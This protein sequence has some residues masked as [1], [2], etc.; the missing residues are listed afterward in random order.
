VNNLWNIADLIDLHFFFQADEEL[1]RREGEAALAKRDRIIYVAKIEPQLGKMDDIPPRILVRKWLAM[2]RLQYRQERG[3]EGQVLPGTLWQELALLCRGLVF[4]CGLLAGLGAAGSLLLYSGTTPL[5]VAVYFGLF[6][7]LQLLLIGVQGLLFGYRQ[8]RRQT[9]ESTVLYAMLGRLLMRGLDGIRRRLQR[10]LSGQRRLDLAALLGGVQQ[11]KE[12]AV[13]LIWP[14]FILVQLGGVGFNLGVLGATLAKVTFADIAFAWQSSLQ[15]SAEMVARLVQWIAL[16]WSWLVP[17]ASPSLA[18][19]QGSQMVLKEG[20][21]HLATAD[22]VAW[23][24]FLCCAVVTY[25]LLPRIGLLMLG[26]LRQRRALSAL[27]FATLSI[28]PLL[29]RMTTPRLDTNGV[30]ER[31]RERQQEPVSAPVVPEVTVPPVVAAEEPPE[32]PA[33]RVFPSGDGAGAFV[34][35]ADEVYDEC[36]RD[37]LMERLRSQWGQERIEWIRHGQPGVPLTESLLPLRGAVE[38]GQLGSVLLLQEAWQPPLRESEQLLR[39]LRR[40]AGAH[41][42][43]TILLIGKPTPQTMLTPV[44][45]EQLRIWRQKMRALGD[46]SLDVQPLVQP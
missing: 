33:S 34:L 10:H 45:P 40:I 2:R 16:P 17:Q 43:L 23:W 18:Q 42:P 9:M 32:A 14:A 29:Q 7:V 6:V 24:P 26:L 30:R 36:P 19:I 39:E 8:L 22:L 15:L 12:L 5:N 4:C 35:I 20:M 44:D 3:H 27:H 25:G 46:P 38:Q 21:T 28:R 13:L 11:R 37:L 31:T 41:T 1:R